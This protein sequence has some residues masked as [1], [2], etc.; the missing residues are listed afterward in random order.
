MRTAANC[1]RGPVAA[2]AA[3]RLARRLEPSTCTCTPSKLKSAASA[4]YASSVTA[5]S[6]SCRLKIA[7]TVDAGDAFCRFCH[8][9]SKRSS[10]ERGVVTP[11]RSA[12][13]MSSKYGGGDLALNITST[14]PSLFA[15]LAR[16]HTYTDV[17]LRRRRRTQVQEIRR[18]LAS[19]HPSVA[20]I[21]LVAW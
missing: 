4:S 13:L 19:L 9:S 7:A 5:A 14:V 8:E 17:C 11:P 15:I 2:T 16:A 21:H 12:H 3:V 6:S 18:F 20:P 10:S 1:P